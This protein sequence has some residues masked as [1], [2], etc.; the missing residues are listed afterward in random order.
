MSFK[1]LLVKKG[2]WPLQDKWGKKKYWMSLSDFSSHCVYRMQD[3]TSFYLK[4]NK[5]KSC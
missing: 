2:K 3:N 5:K 4:T 1:N